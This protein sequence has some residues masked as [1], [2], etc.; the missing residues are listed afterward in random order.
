L[1]ASLWL[2][3]TLLAVAGVFSI[4]LGVWHLGVP[5][6]FDFAGA[7]GPDHGPGRDLRPLR[8]GPFV[9]RTSR[10]DV[11]GLSWVMS[12]AASYVLVSIG[13]VD[14]LAAEWLGTAAGRLLAAWIA[15]WWLLRAVSQLALGRRAVD[16]LALFGFATVGAVHLAAAAA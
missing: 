10:R 1:R 13:I 14:L 2:M 11:L 5:R 16:L 15:G 12:N 7:I 3:T 6:W 9:H 4:G 8:V